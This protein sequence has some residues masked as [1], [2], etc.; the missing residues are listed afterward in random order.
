MNTHWTQSRK[1]GSTERILSKRCGASLNSNR[2]WVEPGF[3]KKAW[4]CSAR[5]VVQGTG[6]L[7]IKGRLQ[8]VKKN[9]TFYKLTFVSVPNVE[10]SIKFPHP[11]C[12]RAKMAVKWISTTDLLPVY[13][14]PFR[15]TPE[16]TISPYGAR[17][18]ALKSSPTWPA[19]GCSFLLPT[20]EE[21]LYPWSSPTVQTSRFQNNHCVPKTTIRVAAVR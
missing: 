19:G 21:C 4:V 20:P 8:H 13:V 2:V 12:F 18:W 7:A 16:G 17:V 6:L 9:I 15:P 3:P 5:F 14:F 10:F 11:A 1:P